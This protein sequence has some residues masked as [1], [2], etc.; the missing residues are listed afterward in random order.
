MAGQIDNRVQ[1]PPP[2][3]IVQVDGVTTPAPPPNT[4]PQRSVSGTEAQPGNPAQAYGVGGVIST[5]A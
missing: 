1:A 5:T 2:T 4:V 3:P